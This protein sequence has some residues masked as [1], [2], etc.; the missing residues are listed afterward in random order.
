[1]LIDVVNQ[2]DRLQRLVVAPSQIEA[3]VLHLT[4]EQHHYLRRVLRLRAGDRF[5]ALDGQGAVWLGVLQPEAARAKLTPSSEWE[6]SRAAVPKPSIILAACLPKQGFDE[7]VRQATELGV[8]QIVPLVS[9]RTLLN[10][11]SNKL[12]RWRRIAAEA[13]EQS[14][15]LT[16][17]VIQDPVS[18]AVWLGRDHQDCDRYVCVAR[19]KAPSLLSVGLAVTQTSFEI[20]VGPEG[21]WTDAEVESAISTGYRPVTL[22]NHILRAVTASVAAISILQAALE[23]ATIYPF[24]DT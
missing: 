18:W 6:R 3:D 20:A 11:S 2:G 5:L 10:P 16:V 15:R 17:P 12:E 14:E 4:N 24:T 1:M 7:V 22:G 8:D 23:F 21:G 9:D 13:G 19:R